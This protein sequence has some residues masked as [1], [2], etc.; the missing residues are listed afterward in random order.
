ME[1]MKTKIKSKSI[2]HMTED[3]IWQECLRMWKWI[4]EQRTKHRQAC[5][6]ALKTKWLRDHNY[7]PRFVRAQC[8]FCE[9][10]ENDCHL[11]PGAKV[12][13]RFKCFNVSYD[14]AHKPKAFYLKLLALNTKRKSKKC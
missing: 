8:F 6:V 11:C 1:K 2:K 7:S 5:I 10:V 14:W 9:K 4:I 13:K 3:K 12:N